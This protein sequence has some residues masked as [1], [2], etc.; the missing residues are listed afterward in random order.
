MGILK[1]IFGRR[2]APQ[3]KASARLASLSAILQSSD[4]QPEVPPQQ[5]SS[6]QPAVVPKEQV[7]TSLTG[8][9][10][11]VVG[12]SN[13][14][15]VFKHITG[16]YRRDSQAFEV[17]AIIA[18][19]PL[20]EYDPHAVRVEI[21]NQIVGYLPKVEAQRIGEM[22]REQ[23]VEKARVQAQ[24]RGGWRTNQHDVG[25]FGVR[26]RMPRDGWIDLGV[27]TKDPGFNT[28]QKTAL[29]RAKKLAPQ[30]AESGPLSYK[31]IVLWG[32]PKDGEVA[33]KIT[34]AG[35]RVLASV[36]K[37]TNLVVTEGPLTL[38]MTESATWRKVEEL[39]SQGH[40][41]EAIAWPELRARIGQESS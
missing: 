18:L 10:L 27:G 33:Q 12:E 8:F 38:G 39:R 26:L 20:N 3:K 13:Y 6:A 19:D 22:M 41:I 24:I 1:I 9:P 37:S 31:C 23:G 17:S 28:V 34:A 5:S 35:G 2:A 40:L 15:D 4:G 14:Q 11:N 25:H 29:A 21:N 36:G 16:G 32:I 7:V 30:P